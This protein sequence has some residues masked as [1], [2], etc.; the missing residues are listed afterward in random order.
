MSIKTNV[1]GQYISWEDLCRNLRS[2]KTVF[3]CTPGKVDTENIVYL[4]VPKY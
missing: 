2:M 3:A 1:E 4:K